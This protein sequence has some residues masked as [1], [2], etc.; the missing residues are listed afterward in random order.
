MIRQ[1]IKL[2]LESN[3]SDKKNPLTF[4]QVLKN[5][6]TELDIS[7]SNNNDNQNLDNEENED[8]IVNNDNTRLNTDATGMAWLLRNN[9]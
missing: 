1:Y 2:F 6:S 3:N 5:T 4:S 8:N 7:N 9:R